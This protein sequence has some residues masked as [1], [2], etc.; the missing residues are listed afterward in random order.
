MTVTLQLT[1][2]QERRLQQGAARNDQE[3]VRRV[4]YQAADEAAEVLLRQTS[5]AR[6]SVDFQAT[7]DELAAFDAPE[8]PEHALTRAGI[9]G[10]HL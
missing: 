2:E 10:D 4:L 6:S 1:A 9:Y 5:R 3:A 8:L 7:L